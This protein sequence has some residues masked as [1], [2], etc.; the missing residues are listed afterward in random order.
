ML[1]FYTGAV[2]TSLDAHGISVSILKIVD[3]HWLELLDTSGKISS[4]WQTTTPSRELQCCPESSVRQVHV[5]IE[6]IGVQV[7]IPTAD[8]IKAS[9][10]NACNALINNE[11]LLNKLDSF[12][13]D[14]DCGTSFKHAAKSNLLL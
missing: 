8:L 11:D 14:G 7:S 1:R 5:A 6:D 13:G 9:L 2:T 10:L 4:L 12:V 3:N